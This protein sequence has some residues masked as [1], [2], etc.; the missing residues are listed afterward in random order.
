[1]ALPREVQVDL[2]ELQLRVDFHE[3]TILVHDFAGG[4]GTGSGDG[5]RTKAVSAL[6]IAHALAR[7]LDLSSGVLPPDALWWAQSGSGT[8]IAVWRPAQ[9]TTLRVRQSYGAKPRRLTLPMPGLVFVC[10]PGGHAPYVFAARERPTKPDDQLF[11]CPTYNVFGSGRV[12]VG[13]H[14][15]PTAPAAVPGAFFESFF[16]VT[17]DTSTGKSRRHP[18]DLGRLWAEIDGADVYPLDDLVPHLT[19]A[20]AMAIGE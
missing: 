2:D 3:E 6:D 4:G 13:T 7:E 11:H 5:V 8:R 15:F 9:A 16:S 14:T 10:L 18:N 17:G 19:V 12:C 1:V 20:D